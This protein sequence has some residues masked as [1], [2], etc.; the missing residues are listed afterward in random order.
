ANGH[1]V[2]DRGRIPLQVAKAF[3]DAHR[4]LAAVG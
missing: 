1:N 3:E 2:S 4:G